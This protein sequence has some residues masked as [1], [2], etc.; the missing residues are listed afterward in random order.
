LVDPIRFELIHPDCGAV[1]RF[2]RGRA[3][4]AIAAVNPMAAAKNEKPRAQI[5][6]SAAEL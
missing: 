4:Q 2:G 6:W 3:L 5:S 1:A